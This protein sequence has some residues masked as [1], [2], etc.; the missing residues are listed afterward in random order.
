[1]HNL[2]KQE[3]S[4]ITGD[5]MIPIAK[6]FID[7]EEVKKVTEV[8]KSG[9]L[10]QGSVVE[11]FEKK[12]SEYVKTK[13]AVA[14]FNG[15]A[16]LDLALKA[17]GIKEGDEIITTPFTF[18]ATANAILY[19]RA[20][21][22][23]AD[24]EEDTYNI[25]PEDVLK[26]ITQKTKAIIGVHI[27]GQPFDVKS[28]LEICEDYKLILIE[29]CAQAHGAEY[30]GKKVGSFGI[31]AFSFYATKNMTTSEGGMIVCNDDE[32][33]RRCRLLRSHGET[34]KYNHEILGYNMRMTNIQ[35]AIGLAQLKKLDWMNERRRKIADYYNHHIKVEG[36]R[37]PIEK[38]GKHVYNQYVL[39]IEDEFPKN[40]DEFSA[41]LT[42][43]G[44]GNAVHY[45]KPIYLQPFYLK[46]GYSKGICPIAEE[47]SKRVISIP[48]HPSL[49][50]KELQYI[51]SVINEVS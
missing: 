12:F 39:Y 45:P 20:K 42:E 28:I 26:K 48:I 47:V 25:N 19:Q 7:D 34:S 3:R 14:V 43:K 18:V 23:F 24:I 41:Y 13:H 31:G 37:K 32:V 8:L 36:I 4:L 49:T 17:C 33:A 22:V 21:P 50:E 6:P 46:L 51:V 15:T 11:E 30:K 1:V 5:K 38:H 10:V 44:I 29:D 27:F 2:K 35:A 9:M 40:R 16:A